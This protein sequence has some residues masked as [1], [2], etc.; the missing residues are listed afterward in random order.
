MFNNKYSL[1]IH[2]GDLAK[3]WPNSA[4]QYNA[5]VYMAIT[6][7]FILTKEPTELAIL[8]DDFSLLTVTSEMATLDLNGRVILS[9]T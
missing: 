9:N 5:I 4:Y 1:R 8:N 2:L 3:T 7:N 6:G